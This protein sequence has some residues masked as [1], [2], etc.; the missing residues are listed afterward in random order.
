[1]NPHVSTIGL[2]IRCGI[3]SVLVLCGAGAATRLLLVRRSGAYLD[4][5]WSYIAG[6]VHEGETGWQ[7]A[8]REL[9]EETGLVPEAFYATSF[10]EQFYRAQP[11]GIEIVPAFVARVG[12]RAEVRLNH[13]HSACRWVDLDEAATLLPFGSQRDLLAHVRREFVERTPSEALRIEPG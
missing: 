1:M 3:V 8:R 2:P 6:H 10:C 11:E 7:A 9:F 13:E 12:E 5:V 4:G